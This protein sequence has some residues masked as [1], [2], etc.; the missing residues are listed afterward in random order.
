M[1]LFLSIAVVLAILAGLAFAFAPER[2]IV[3]EVRIDAPPERVWSVLTDGAAYGSWNPF[4]VSMKGKIA[5]GETIENIMEPQK[6]KQMTFLPKVLVAEPGRELRWLGRVLMPRIF[7]GEHYILLTEQD[8]GTRLVHGE[9]FRGIGLWFIDAE[10]FR[11][12]FEAMNAALK[13][14]VESREP[15]SIEGRTE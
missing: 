9:K 10:Q 5:K 3:T 13:R 1:K 7:D 12:N 14:S 8:G 15:D 4:I 6:G 11:P 2:E